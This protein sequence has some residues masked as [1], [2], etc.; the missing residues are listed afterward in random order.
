MNWEPV[1]GLEIH[2]HLKTRTKMFCRCEIAYGELREHANVPGLPRVPRAPARAERE[3]DRVDGQARPRARLRDRRA[4]DLP[5]Q[6][7][8]LPGHRRRRTRSP[9]TTSRCAWTGAWSSRSDGDKEVGI[10]R[11]HLEEDAAKNV[12]VGGAEGRISGASATLVDFNRGRHAAGRDRHA[13]GHPLGGR[14][15]PFPAAAPPDRRRARDLRC[16][17]G[18]GLASLRRQRLRSRGRRA[19]RA[20]NATELKNMNSFTFVA[21]AIEA[22]SSAR[23]GSTRPGTR[24][25]GDAPLR[26]GHGSAPPLRSKEEAHDY[27]YFPEPDLVPIEPPA[28]LVER[29]RAE[30]PELPAARIRRL[31]PRAGFDLAEGLVTSGRDSLY[32]RVPRDRRAVANVLMNQFAAPGVDPDAVTRTSSAS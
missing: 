28:E 25:T 5:P 24:S 15:A 3:G 6:E 32:E 30:L 7:L 1:I 16:R 22:R 26:P 9:S 31:E 27:R 12:H 18:E 4:R 2:V 13:A 19:P 17:D 20:S 10:V 21:G 8:L 23:S 11:A 14:G 29:A